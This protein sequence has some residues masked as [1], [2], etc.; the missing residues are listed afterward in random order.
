VRRPTGV[1][2]LALWHNGVLRDLS[3][4]SRAPLR[5]LDTLLALSLSEIR[6]LIEEPET[7]N[8]PA[9]DPASIDL[10]PPVESQE[11]WA[12]GVTYLRSRDARMEE[13]HAKTIYERVYMAERPELFFK[14]AGW[15]VV[16]CSK[17]VGVRSDSEWNVPEPELALMTNVHGEVVACACGNDMSSRSIEGENPL[18]FSQAKIYDASC[19]IGP[20][21]VF[22]W[23]V[24][25]H[26]ITLHMTITREATEVFSG[27]ARVADMVREPLEL[28]SVMH[29]AY[30][31]PQGAWLLT[32]TS[33]VPPSSYTATP[34][35]V[36]T[37]SIGELGKLVNGVKLIQ[38]SGAAAKPRRS[39]S[40][41]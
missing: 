32:G 11:V 13:A 16:P 9:I 23:Q 25:I 40:R 31:L 20:A 41:Q 35:D 24:E 38:H 21:A 33:I 27:S 5:A 34:R 14:C 26:K 30:S 10:L 19:S 3:L 4:A 12:A 7:D 37:I 17:E 39:L 6:A 15:R 29:A 8:L 2:S 28:A 22:A 36:I 18:Y 1:C